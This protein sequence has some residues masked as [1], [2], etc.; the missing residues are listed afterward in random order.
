MHLLSAIVFK[1]V[2]VSKEF[3]E[4]LAYS[5]LVELNSAFI[6]R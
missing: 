1:L 2:A 4:G 6:S 3:L 5:V